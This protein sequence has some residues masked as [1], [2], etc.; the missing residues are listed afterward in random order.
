MK[1]S[2]LLILSGIVLFCGFTSIAQVKSTLS[3]YDLKGKVKSADVKVV[4][5]DGAKNEYYAF[6]SIGKITSRKIYDGTLV[7]VE[8]KIFTGEEHYFRYDNLGHLLE[9]TIFDKSKQSSKINY[10]YDN[11][12]NII[13]GNAKVNDVTFYTDIKSIFQYNDQKQIVKAFM[14]F[15]DSVHSK[16]FMKFR[17]EFTNDEKGRIIETKSYN[18]DGEKLISDIKNEY[19]ENGDYAVIENDNK[20]TSKFEFDSSGNWI[21]ETVYTSLLSK[22]NKLNKITQ[23]RT[24]TIV[25]Y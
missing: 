8:N 3:A 2:R 12:G 13:E 5:G 9:E 4:Q 1:S 19:Y 23:I 7:I 25:Y 15:F 17:L 14:I 21:K 24:R 22:P 6:D 10:T 11:S 18:E 16:N 20:K